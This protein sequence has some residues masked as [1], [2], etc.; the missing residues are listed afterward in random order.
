MSQIC[1]I[2]I[3]NPKD[4]RV[5]KKEILR[6]LRVAKSDFN[7]D[8]LVDECLCDAYEMISPRAVALETN[9]EILSEDTVKLDFVTME[10]RSLATTLNGYNKAYVFS[11]TIGSQLDRAIE[12]YSKL[13]PSRATVYHAV[14]TAL[15]ESFCDY[16]NELLIKGRSSTRRFSP[17][18]GDL[19]LEYQRDVI[20]ALDAQR[21]I[22]V[23]LAKSLLMTPSKTVTA[24]IG[25]K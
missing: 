6:Y 1:T 16:V 8:L 14:G 18:Y 7:V 11:A 12:K 13:S 22:G 5:D 24:I 25:V 15:V 9:V 3:S 4:L 19:S 17:G 23:I 21:K 10:S 2:S 20:K